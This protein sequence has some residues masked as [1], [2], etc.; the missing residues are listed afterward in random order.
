MVTHSSIL[1][2]EITDRGAW[3]TAVHRLQRAA[4]ARVSMCPRGQYLKHNCDFL[5][6]MIIIWPSPYSERPTATGDPN[7]QA[8]DLYLWSDQQPH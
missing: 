1:S 4:A 6:N 7:L 2:W 8:T 3:R 5:A